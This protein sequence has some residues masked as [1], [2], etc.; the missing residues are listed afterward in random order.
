MGGRKFAA[1][2][3]TSKPDVSSEDHFGDFLRLAG[4]QAQRIFTGRTDSFEFCR[5]VMDRLLKRL[6]CP[7]PDKA[8]SGNCFLLHDNA[9]SHNATIVEQFLAMKSVTI[10]YHLPYSPDL[11]PAD[12]FLLPKVKSNLM[13][14]LFD[15]I[16]EIQNYVTSELKSIPAA[17]FYRG[18]QQLY[19]RANRGIELGGMFVEGYEVI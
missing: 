19:D 15:G 10:P 9:P 11:V 18:I 2:K 13:E 16:L 12:Y 1:A 8:Q 17:E 6:R 14:L 5:E 3:E 7:R 4:S